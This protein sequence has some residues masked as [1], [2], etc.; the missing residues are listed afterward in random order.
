[1]RTS[2]PAKPCY[3]SALSDHYTLPDQLWPQQERIARERGAHIAVVLLLQMNCAALFGHQ[4]FEVS[5]QQLQDLMQN[6]SFC[7]RNF[8]FHV[9]PPGQKLIASATAEPDAFAHE[10]YFCALHHTQGL[11]FSSVQFVCRQL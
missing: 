5:A 4:E 11:L 9:P 1:M 2:L 3:Q 7:C 10:D 6:S 8:G